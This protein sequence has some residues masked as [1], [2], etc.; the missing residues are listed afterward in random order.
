MLMEDD[1]EVLEFRASAGD[2]L[3]GSSEREVRI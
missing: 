1:L 3:S 2:L